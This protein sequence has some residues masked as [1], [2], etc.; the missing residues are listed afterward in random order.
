MQE[1]VTDKPSPQQSNYKQSA[2]LVKHLNTP[3]HVLNTINFR[4]TFDTNAVPHERNVHEE[5]HPYMYGVNK[6]LWLVQSWRMISNACCHSVK[7]Y[8]L[9]VS[10]FRL[11][12]F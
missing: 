9:T 12:H 4:T 7:L 11:Q 6:Q 2:Q 10:G 3:A 5:Q 1:A 8:A